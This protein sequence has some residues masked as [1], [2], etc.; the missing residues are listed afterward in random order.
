[1]T[2]TIKDILDTDNLNI[3][4][5]VLFAE[6]ATH[7]VPCSYSLAVLMKFRI[8]SFFQNY[9]MQFLTMMSLEKTGMSY[10]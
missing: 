6:H 2:K 9:E 3:R 4:G 1:M 8:V 7:S 5:T 10:I